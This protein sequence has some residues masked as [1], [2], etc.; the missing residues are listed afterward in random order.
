M[1]ESNS[2]SAQGSSLSR[3]RSLVT[4][5]PLSPDNRSKNACVRRLKLAAQMSDDGL[6]MMRMRFRRED[7]SLNSMG[8]DRL[9]KDWLS[10]SPEP[11]FV[12]GFTVQNPARF[13]T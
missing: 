7:A 3:L 4:E 12:E 13:E 9:I 10:D 8:V 2:S 11:G 6:Q 5:D 1:D